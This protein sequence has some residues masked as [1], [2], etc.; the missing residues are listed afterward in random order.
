[1][2][3]KHIKIIKIISCSVLTVIVLL[4]YIFIVRYPGEYDPDGLIY[5]GKYYFVENGM[6][7]SYSPAQGLK[8]LW[9]TYGSDSGI[10]VEGSTLFYKK[11]GKQKTLELE[12]AQSELAGDSKFITVDADSL[13]VDHRIYGAHVMAKH[14]GEAIVLA[15]K[16]ADATA[17]ALYIIAEDG[18]PAELLP[19]LPDVFAAYHYDGEW[20]YAITPIYNSK[21]YSYQL[22]RDDNA[23]QARLVD[24]L[25]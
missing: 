7:W 21:I 2:A 16:Y 4:V 1:M 23:I 15:S 8:G 24:I 18:K 25:K 5:N 20:L 10:R 17:P 13:R 14:D 6:V 3:E 19:E 11:N 22:I 9:A 12:A